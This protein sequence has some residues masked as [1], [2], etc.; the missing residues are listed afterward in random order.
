LIYVVPHQCFDLDH[1][2]DFEIISYLIENDKLD[3]KL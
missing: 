2:L 1:P 3:F